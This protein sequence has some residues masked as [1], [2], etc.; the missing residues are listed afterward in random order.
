MLLCFEQ[1]SNDADQS[2]EIVS[3][4]ISNNDQS[5]E[6]NHN[7]NWPYIPGHP[8]RNVIIGGSGSRKT[9]ALLN[10]I[11]NQ[12]PNFDKIYLFVKDPFESKFQLLINRREKV[13][14]EK[15]KNLKAFIDY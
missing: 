7:P 11:K 13:G 10:L 4:S 12:W 1:I 15:L 5:F 14:I 8:Y 6:I 3:W 2:V 9:S